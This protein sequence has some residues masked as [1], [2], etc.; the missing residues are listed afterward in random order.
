MN[1]LIDLTEKMHIMS[2]LLAQAEFAQKQHYLQINVIY[3]SFR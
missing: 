1:I 3:L 2:S